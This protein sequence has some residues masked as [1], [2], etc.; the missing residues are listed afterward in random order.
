MSDSFSKGVVSEFG[1]EILA[2]E[3]TLPLL[4]FTAFFL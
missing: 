4:F 1:N 3:K 2:Y